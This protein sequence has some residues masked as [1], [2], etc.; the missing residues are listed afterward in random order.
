MSPTTA[1]PVTARKSRRP[2]DIFSSLVT[3]FDRGTAE[4]AKDIG[5]SAVRYG[6]NLRLLCGYSIATH[7]RRAINVRELDATIAVCAPQDNPDRL[8]GA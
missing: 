5:R 7:K 3:V 6:F 4:I 2:S 1:L 8:T